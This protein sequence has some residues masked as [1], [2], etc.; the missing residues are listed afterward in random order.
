MP[1]NYDISDEQRERLRTATQRNDPNKRLEELATITLEIGEENDVADME[2]LATRI[3]THEV[4]GTGLGMSLADVLDHLADLA[5][6]REDLDI[7]THGGD[8]ALLDE[9]TLNERFDHDV[10]FALQTLY[11][12]MIYDKLPN[13]QKEVLK[14][15]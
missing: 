14:L 10:Y 7:P 6:L 3:G 4:V 9:L 12:E 1:S 13:H 2:A 11:G 15:R 8:A 5:R